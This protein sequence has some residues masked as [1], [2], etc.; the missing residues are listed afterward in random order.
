MKCRPPEN[1]N[2]KSNEIEK[3]T[4]YLTEQIKFV[5][6]QVIVPVGNFSARFVLETKEGI[7]KL[8]G[9]SYVVHGRHVVPSVHPAYVLRNGVR[10]QNEMLEDLAIAKSLLKV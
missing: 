4:N 7:M 8:R 9:R 6:P 3:C 1:R 5:D 2:P 10:G